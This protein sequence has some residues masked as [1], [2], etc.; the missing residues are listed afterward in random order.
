MDLFFTFRTPILE[1][2]IIL[3]VLQTAKSWSRLGLRLGIVAN[4][5][6]LDFDKQLLGTT[7]PGLMST[8]VMKMIIVLKQY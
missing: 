8:K 3:D 7:C 1:D 6:D 5:Q 4:D 2:L